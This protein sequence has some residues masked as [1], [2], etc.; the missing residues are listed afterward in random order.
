M[1][2]PTRIAAATILA[3]A[4][5][6]LAACQNASPPKQAAPAP[7]APEPV[8]P[9][10]STRWPFAFTWKPSPGADWI[11][12]VQV[13]DSA[14]RVILEL[15]TRDATI[16]APPSLREM[17]GGPALFSWCV[18]VQ[19]RDGTALARSAPVPFRLD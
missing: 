3:I 5:L 18:V 2:T 17:L 13:I 6:S 14:E 4:L 7:A 8:A 12:R 19:G 9:R 16:A 11:Y 1:R 10:G 15:E